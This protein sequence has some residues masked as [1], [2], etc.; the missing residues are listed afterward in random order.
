MNKFTHNKVTLISISILILLLSCTVIPTEGDL[1]YLRH[2]GADMPVLV[3]GNSAS[4]VF[5]VYIHGGPGGSTFI[6]TYNDLFAGTNARYS[7]VSYDQR[8]SGNSQGVSDTSL[9]TLEQYVEDLGMVVDY[10]DETYDADKIILLGHSWGGMLGT[11]YM[12]DGYNKEKVDAWIEVDGGHNMGQSAYE[13]SRDYVLERV[14]SILALPDL[15]EKLSVQW[16]EIRNYYD[17]IDSWKDPEVVIKHSKHVTAVEGY[18]YDQA[19]REGLVGLNEV[20]LSGTNFWALLVQ[21]EF[22]INNMDVWDLDFT[23]RLHEI[24]V[25]TLVLWGKYDGIL[26]VELGLQAIEAM[27]LDEDHYF[28]FQETDHSPQYEETELFNQKVVEFIQGL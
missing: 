28:I 21:N 20:L 6:D 19:N 7:V 4:G 8:S 22:V 26:P 24:D 9:I 17:T 11:A 23:D 2:K 18:F 1:I 25:P 12:L 3:Q 14:D 15:S 13:L 5:L 27:D 16:Q 10:I